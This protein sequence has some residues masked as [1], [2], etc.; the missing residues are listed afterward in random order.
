M[1]AV[2]ALN[3]NL[4]TDPSL[5]K[6]NG[7]KYVCSFTLATSRKY[8][9]ENDTWA[10]KDKLFLE[11]ECWGALAQHVRTS[12]AK[13]MPAVCMGS[14]YTDSYQTKEGQPASKVKM[15]ANTVALDLSRHVAFAARL[16]VDGSI[17]LAKVNLLS[18]VADPD[19]DYS[20]G[21]AHQVQKPELSTDTVGGFSATST[22]LDPDYAESSSGTGFSGTGG[23]DSGQVR[24]TQEPENKDSGA[25]GLGGKGTGGGSRG[26]DVGN[27]VAQ[28]GDSLSERPLVGA[29]AAG[30]V[31]SV[32]PLRSEDDATNTS[33]AVAP[34]F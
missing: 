5:R 3:G 25:D 7:E 34:P 6:L 22:E 28:G 15:R 2:I 19:S 20:G 21:N 8:K 26:A 32:H 16:D 29:A 10:E 1:S 30:S 14:L 24:E 23:K 18:R 17:P 11:V 33:G 12:L 4:A 9:T 27:S 31:G 13:G